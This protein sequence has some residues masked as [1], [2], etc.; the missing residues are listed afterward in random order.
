M[1]KGPGMQEGWSGSGAPAPISRT[2]AGKREDVSDGYIVVLHIDAANH[3][4]DIEVVAMGAASNTV[5]KLLSSATQSL[6]RGRRPQL[7]SAIDEA[8]TQ[9]RPLIAARLGLPKASQPGSP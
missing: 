2:A 7:R 6:G 4:G 1:N 9:A 3:G 8:L 5:E